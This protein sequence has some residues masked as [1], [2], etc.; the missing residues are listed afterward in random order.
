MSQGGPNPLK[1]Y[2]LSKEILE[3]CTAVYYENDLEPPPQRY[4]AAVSNPVPISDSLVVAYSR[5]FHGMPAKPDQ[6]YASR[7]LM[8]PRSASF[9][10]WV[11][12][13]LSDTLWGEGQVQLDLVD[14]DGV[15]EDSKVMMTDAYLLSKGIVAAH[16]AGQLGVDSGQPVGLGD[17][18][19]LPAA[20]G[21]GGMRFEISFEMV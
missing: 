5:M 17:V 12:R 20:G 8:T 11:F 15:D 14:L 21:V 19:P 1:L 16:A 10:I 9:G 6:P 4:V 18:L 2:D 7:G 3:A 13:S